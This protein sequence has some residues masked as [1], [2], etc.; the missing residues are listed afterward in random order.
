VGHP[1]GSPRDP[2]YSVSLA[3]MM[4]CAFYRLSFGAVGRLTGTVREGRT[5][6]VEFHQSHVAEILG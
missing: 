1:V 3:F 5:I 2:T 6:N 4:N